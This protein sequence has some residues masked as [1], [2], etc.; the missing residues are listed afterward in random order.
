MKRPTIRDV[1]AAAGVSKS[2]VS[3]VYS[4]EDGVSPERRERVLAAAQKLGFT[5][6][7][8]A[9]SLASGSGNFIGIL[10]VDLHN[11]IYTEVADLA[12]RALLE[13]GQ[14][15][16][17]AA[18]IISERKGKKF[19]EKSTIQALLDLRPN[20][21]IVVGDLPEESALA[22]I[23][24][25][26]PIV[27][28]IATLRKKDRAVSIRSDDKEAMSLVVR[29]LRLR[30][31]KKIQYIGPTDGA[32]SEQRLEAFKHAMEEQGLTPKVSTCERTEAG[33]NSAAKAALA[34]KNPPTALVFFNDVLAVGAQQAVADH[35]AAGKPFV[36]VTG[37]DNTYLSEL[38]QISLT[39][40]EPEKEAIALK[41]AELI[42]DPELVASM[43]GQE[44]LMVPRLI[45][46]KST[47]FSQ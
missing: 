38:S 23:P 7:Q 35:V 17:M 22:S 4:R 39:T 26:V 12:R 16:F 40:I 27:K 18:A 41:A 31:H 42:T 33:A 5:P 32:V 36:A 45:V 11:L 13:R 25:S 21:I 24:D 8:W 20:G 46:R 43:A 29:H 44:I 37:F 15:T 3:M 34:E 19:V 30:G 10:V 14:Q 28:T 2:L 47:D 1:A 9:R 6:N